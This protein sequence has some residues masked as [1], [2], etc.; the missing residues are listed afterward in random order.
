MSRF[1]DKKVTWDEFY[2]AKKAIK[3][4]DVKFNNIVISQ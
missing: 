2:A 4:C 3:V 1:E